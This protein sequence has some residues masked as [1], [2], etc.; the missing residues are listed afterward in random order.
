[1][2]YSD[3]QE[4]CKYREFKEIYTEEKLIEENLHMKRYQILP[5]RYMTNENEIAKRFLIYHSPGTGK[6][7]TA[8]WI[9]LNFIDIY[10]K[11]SIILVKSKEAI[12]EFKQRVALWY[13]Y[14]YN[15]R[16]PPTGITNYHQFIKRYIEFHTYITF[17]K[18]VETIK[19]ISLYENRLLIIDEIHH[20]R[21]TVGNKI[22]YNKLLKF[23]NNIKDSRVLFMS[24]TPIF[25]NYNEITSLVKL[26]KPDFDFSIKITPEKLEEIM[27]G[28]VSYYGLNPPDT[29]VNFIGSHVPRIE[30]FKI[31]K[32]SMKGLQLENYKTLASESK[33]ICNIGI[34]HVKATLGVIGFKEEDSH[35]NYD[36][37][38]NN[39]NNSDDRYILKNENIINSNSIIQNIIR[40][41]SKKL[42]NYCCKLHE[43][44]KIINSENSPDGPVFIYCNIIDEVGI[45]YF[46]ALLC[47]MGYK[48][49]Y[50][51]KSALKFGQKLSLNENINY[52]ELKE[53]RINRNKK[54][55]NF[56]FVTGDKR[57]CPN[58]ME[59]LGIFNDTSNRNGTTIKVLLGSDIL[60]ESVDIMNIR[61][62]HILTPH[63]NYE[64]INQI[65]GRICRVGSHDA[66]P[67]HQ[68]NVNI[69]LYMAYN[70]DH[71]CEYENSI[72]YSI[73]YV[74]YIISEKKYNQ[75][76]MYNN[77]LQNASIESLICD[78]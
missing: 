3:I 53:M 77:A 26:I 23:L 25:D 5:V 47:E 70:S 73:D 15:Y 76:L 29:S 44:L 4:L 65:I 20:F 41:Q 22:I 11:P 32:V 69:Y 66:L 48:Y 31:F 71:E 9:L 27:K 34:S 67:P 19:D 24:A 56:T 40:K 57:L 38:N 72:N 62:L 54:K 21:N 30:R 14:T 18:S 6:S 49:I 1:M 55:W 60:S 7:F 59:R 51:K 10:K 37:N 33:S 58:V 50:D 74:K 61:Q 13:A 35:D 2:T 36:E 8:L 43:C 39:N 28:H 75:A 17:C 12:M 52:P 45:Y 64:K 16:Q 78:N 46:A 42:E 63:W 68:R